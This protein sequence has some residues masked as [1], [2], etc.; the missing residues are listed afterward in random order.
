MK[1]WRTILRRARLSLII[2]AGAIV[3]SLTLVFGSEYIHNSMREGLMQ[4][5][6]QTSAQQ[7]A[8]AEKNQDLDYI[9]THIGQFRLL[10]E[11]GLLSTPDRENWAEQLL[12]ARQHLR[13]PDTLTYALPPAASLTSAATTTEPATATDGMNSSDGVMIHDLEISMR[14]IQEEELLALLQEFQT[15][16]KDHFRVQFCRLSAPIETGLS[17]QCQL[18]FFTLPAPVVA[19]PPA[20]AA[21]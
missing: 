5:H 11:Q 18:R 1:P 4:Q 8:L 17:A 20:N 2:L 21:S 10:R 13:L 3:F 15:R 12:A 16:I 7:A 14:D 6:A 9:K 19:S